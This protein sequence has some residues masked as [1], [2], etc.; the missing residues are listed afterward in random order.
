[1]VPEAPDLPAATSS[2]L[3]GAGPLQ[4][5]TL[6]VSAARGTNP[7]LIRREDARYHRAAELADDPSL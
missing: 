1:M 2:L 4:L 3:G 6:A 7:D 5:V